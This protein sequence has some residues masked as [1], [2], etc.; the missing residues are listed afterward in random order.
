MSTNDLAA[1]P[2]INFSPALV[3]YGQDDGGR[4]H[5]SVFA[6][7]DADLAEKAAGLMGM[8]AFRLTDPDHLATVAGLPQGRV[9]ASG[10]AFVPYT[11]KALYDRLTALGGAPE[12]KPISQPARPLDRSAKTKVADGV[13]LADAKIGKADGDET[14]PAAASEN[15]TNPLVV[16]T[17]VLAPEV[18]ASWWEAVV[19]AA[20]G[21]SV[22]LKWRD[23][24]AERPFQRTRNQV[25]AMPD[26]YIPPV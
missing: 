9:F 8:R 16:G 3:V 13:E 4:P 24:P 19:V 7:S 20:K 11:K 12:P 21:E 22:T 2:A 6:E 15:R 18:G 5:A 10:K 25:A 14:A 23:F 26:R 1:V 17:V